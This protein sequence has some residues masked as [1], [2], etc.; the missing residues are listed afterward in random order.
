MSSKSLAVLIFNAAMPKFN[1]GV[2]KFAD[3]LI[4]C[5]T[6]LFDWNKIGEIP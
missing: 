4:D 6:I 2:K 3:K 1:G 5:F